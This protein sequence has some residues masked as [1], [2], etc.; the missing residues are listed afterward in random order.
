MNFEELEAKPLLAAAG[1]AVPA[2]ELAYSVRVFTFT[3]LIR[4]AILVLRR[5][6]VGFELG[7]PPFVKWLTFLIFIGLWLS[8]I[9]L[10]IQH[11]NSLVAGGA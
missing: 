7:G 6:T 4:L 8:Y 1:I 11:T 9:S 5:K 3:A 10:S 2:G